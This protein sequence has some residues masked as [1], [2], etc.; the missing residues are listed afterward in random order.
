MP[1]VHEAFDFEQGVYMGATA[2]SEPTAAAL[3]LGNV[4]LRFDPF[5]MTPFIGYHAGDYMQHWFDMGEKLGDKAP[6]CF[7]VNWFRKDENG[8]FMWPGFGEN[9]RVLK[10][11]CDRV[12]GK[13]GAVETPIG[14]MPKKEEFSFEGLDVSDE[15][16]NELMKVDNAAFLK[17]VENAKEYLAKFGDKLPTQISAQLEKLEARLNG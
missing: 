7:Y 16:W 13:V 9:S 12:E 11:M 2:S 14:L 5:A 15:V 4:S 17:T 8:K 10:W 3:D 6:K 1:L